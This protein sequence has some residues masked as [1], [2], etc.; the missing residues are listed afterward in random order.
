MSRK[1][2]LESWHKDKAV[3]DNIVES[4]LCIDC[5]VNTAPGVPDGPT[6]R[7]DIALKGKSETRYDRNTEVYAVKDA[8]WEQA[9]MRPWSGCLCVGCL[10]KRI[11]RQLRPKDFTRHDRE[12]WAEMPCTERLLNRRGSATVTVQTRDGPREVICALEH[13]PLINGAVMEEEEAPAPR[14]RHRQP[15][16]VEMQ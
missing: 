12:V 16:T 11:G 15:D 13:A 4:W 5:G 3:Q 8:I 9:G 7:I 2:D 1:K 14:R 6:T 10:E